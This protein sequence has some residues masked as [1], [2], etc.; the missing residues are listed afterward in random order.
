MKTHCFN[1]VVNQLLRLVDF[2]FSVGHDET[3]QVFLLVTGVSSIRSTFAL[4]DRAFTT[5]S[6]LGTG[7]RFHF[8]ECVTTRTNQ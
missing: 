4:L 1:D 3:M 6:N 7:L 5:N 2:V 8:L